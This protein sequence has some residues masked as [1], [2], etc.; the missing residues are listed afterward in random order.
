MAAPTG[1]RSPSEAADVT[2]GGSTTL[3]RQRCDPC[4][5]TGQIKTTCAEVGSFHRFT[6]VLGRFM[7]R[8][9]SDVSR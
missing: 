9:F 2:D 6:Q 3:L 7:K 8:C 1:V 5:Y 4:I